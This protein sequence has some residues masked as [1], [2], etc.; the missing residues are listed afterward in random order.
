MGFA[1]IQGR[2]RSVRGWTAGRGP[3]LASALVLAGALAA[4]RA[5]RAPPRCKLTLELIDSATGKPVP[6]LVKI[7][8]GAGRA[9][10]LEGLLSRGEGLGADSPL[11]RWW[12]VPGPVTVSLPAEALDLEAFG[13]LETETARQ[14]LE[15]GGKAE[16]RLPLPL[17][18]FHDAA[19]RGLASANTHL[20]LNRLEKPEAERYLREIP[21]ADGLDLVFLSHLERAGEDAGYVSNRFTAADLEGLSRSGVL[22]ANGEEH[23][24][25]FGA[26]G[27]GYGHVML[28]DILRHIQPVS[29]GP[30]IMKRG[31]DGTPL[32]AGI[33]AARGD[34]AT[35]IWCH[36]DWGFEDV[37]SWLAARLDAQN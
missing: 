33:E 29:I 25:N 11:W 28:L 32:R 12:V 21:R 24:H 16:V 27:E 23:R 10:P 1:G 8:D 13:G 5:T 35:A 7:E 6:G 22:F 31:T 26:Q 34:G 20:H 15:L 3:F 18:R 4:A 37:P 30:G 36:N 9:V 19:Q 2:F 14:R 17:R